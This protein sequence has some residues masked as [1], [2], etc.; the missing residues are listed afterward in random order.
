MFIII[1]IIA[2]IFIIGV[3][4]ALCKSP[5][6]YEDEKGFHKGEKNGTIR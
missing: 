1:L 3:M 4:F 6:G 5:I 2:A